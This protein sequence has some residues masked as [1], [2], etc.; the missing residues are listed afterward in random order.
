[1]IPPAS[2]H[3]SNVVLLWTGSCL[4]CSRSHKC[5]PYNYVLISAVREA[6]P[7]RLTLQGNPHFP[8]N[9]S[10]KESPCLAGSSY[11]KLLVT[12]CVTITFCI[13]ILRTSDGVFTGQSSTNISTGVPRYTRLRVSTCKLLAVDTEL[14]E[15]CH[16]PCVGQPQDARQMIL[17]PT[18][19]KFGP[20]CFLVSLANILAGLC[21][22]RSAA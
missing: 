21:S 11:S 4:E 15:A 5:R 18:F 7:T 3:A 10:D 8:N 13:L 14:H 1:M 16:C 12:P 20:V 9:C 22:M 6:L 17:L 2:L 19:V